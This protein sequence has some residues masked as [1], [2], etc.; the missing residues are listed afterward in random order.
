MLSVWIGVALIVISNTLNDISYRHPPKKG[1]HTKAS[2]IYLG[3]TILS[4]AVGGYLIYDSYKRTEK[5]EKIVYQTTNNITPLGKNNPLALKEKPFV[6][7][8]KSEVFYQHTPNRDTIK[9]INTFCNRTNFNAF[10]KNVEL[11]YYLLNAESVIMKGRNV[12][13][14]DFILAKNQDYSI[15]ANVTTGYLQQADSLYLYFT[16]TYSNEKHTINKKIHHVLKWGRGNTD[17][18]IVLPEQEQSILNKMQLLKL[19]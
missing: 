5:V 15:M 7:I 2:N 4:T 18:L 9:L 1:K 12:I 11:Y 8:C 16:G 6:F 3:L 10:I 14:K 13:F 17:I 19:F